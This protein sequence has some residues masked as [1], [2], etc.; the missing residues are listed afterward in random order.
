MF[1]KAIYSLQT[2]QKADKEQIKSFK[3]DFKPRCH[4]YV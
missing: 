2:W 3:C 4:V 1:E